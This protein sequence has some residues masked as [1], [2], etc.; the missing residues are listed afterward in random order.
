[1]NVCSS[2]PCPDAARMAV[3]PANA[4]RPWLPRCCLVALTLCILPPVPACAG[5]RVAAP[6]TAAT[7]SASPAVSAALLAAN[8]QPEAGARLWGGV[9]E[10]VWSALGNRRHLLQIGL[11]GMAAA[12]YII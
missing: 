1:M 2:S 10:P 9:L 7:P 3:R 8:S 11:I 6:V 4:A 12:L 5:E